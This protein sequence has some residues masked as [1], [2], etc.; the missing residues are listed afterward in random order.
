[1]PS[2]PKPQA[3]RNIA[4]PFSL[5]SLN[6]SGGPALRSSFLSIVRRPGP[7]PGSC[8]HVLAAHLEQYVEPRRPSVTAHFGSHR[9]GALLFELVRHA[10]ESG[11]ELAAEGSWC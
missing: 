2:N 3:W 5:C 4:S 10:G 1:M 8:L 11:V 7:A 6:S 9:W